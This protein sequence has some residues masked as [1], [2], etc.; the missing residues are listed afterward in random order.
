M[1]DIKFDKNVLKESFSDIKNYV[2]IKILECYKTV[3]QKE[4]ILKNFGFYILGI[5]FTSN[6]IC[7]FLF[8]FKFYNK[9]INI[10]QNLKLNLINNQ[11]ISMNKNNIKKD[12]D[13]KS[14]IAFKKGKRKKRKEGNKKNKKDL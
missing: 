4:N 3:F 7:L 9:L 11:K 14:Y 13:A 8:Y 5:L 2:N 12:Q 10:L 6:I 1:K